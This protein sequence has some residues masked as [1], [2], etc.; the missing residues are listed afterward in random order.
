MT[1]TP[2]QGSARYALD[3]TEFLSDFHHTTIYGAT[4]NNGIDRQAGTKEHGQV[5]DWFE[6]QATK[7]GFRVLTDTIGNIFALKDWVP[8]APYIVVGS[9]LDSQPLGGRFDGTYGVIA[10]LHGAA[11]LDQAVTDGD[12]TPQFNV[13][14]VDWFNEEGGR[15]APS[16]MGSSVFVGLFELEA[17]LNTKDP[18][19]I[20]VQEA[21]ELT[22][23]SGTAI[24]LAVAGYAELHIEQ[25]RRLER[26][27]I[28]I[29]V[30]DRSWYTQKLLVTVTGEQSHTGATIMS[31]RR[32]A[33]VAASHVVIMAEEVVEEFEPETIVTSVGKFDV[34]PNSPI[35]VPRQV[36]LVV[37]LRADEKDDVL[38]ARSLLIER[39]KA[40]ATRRSVTITFED[41][42]IRPIQRFPQDAVS[43]GEKAAIDDGMEAQ[44]L[45]TMAGHDSVAMNRVTPSVMLFVPSV[46]GV[47]HCEREFTTDDDLVAGLK[48]LTNLVGRMVSGELDGVAPGGSLDS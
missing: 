37:D 20:T 23:R 12:L 21:L 34:E 22:G 7:R 26:S 17:M 14:V 11:A 5:R 13:A 31:D 8:G 25:G 35:V 36:K 39:M 33:L 3:S 4:K 16:I 10:A 45:A 29:G 42:D 15:F 27:G 43:L 1:Q 19:G 9:H 38:R 2:A 40:L 24:D 48:A 30:V 18:D 32:D 41:F 6:E 46:D 28:P 44:V 47:S